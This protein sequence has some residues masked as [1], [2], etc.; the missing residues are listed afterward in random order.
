MAL[1]AFVNDGALDQFIE[2]YDVDMEEFFEA[3]EE[4]V[5]VCGY[6][7]DEGGEGEIDFECIKEYLEEDGNLVADRGRMLAQTEFSGMDSIWDQIAERWRNMFGSEGVLVDGLSDQEED[8]VAQTGDC[9]GDDGN[10]DGG[11]DGK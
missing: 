10:C 6:D 5:E 3:Y 2:Y 7:S 11:E 1:N 9:A 8:E 4:A